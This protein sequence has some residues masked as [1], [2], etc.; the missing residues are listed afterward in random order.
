MPAV[1]RSTPVITLIRVD[2]PGTVVADQA[3]DLVAAD[4]E[5]DVAQRLDGAEIHLDALQADDVGEVRRP[6]RALRRRHRPP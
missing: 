5:V 6:L 1:G 2:L 4:G 3:D